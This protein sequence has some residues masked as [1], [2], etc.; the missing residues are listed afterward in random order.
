MAAR[1]TRFVVA[2]F[3]R[4]GYDDVVMATPL[5]AFVYNGTKE[6]NGYFRSGTYS[7]WDAS[8]GYPA[9]EWFGR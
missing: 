9:A 6:S 8:Y 4:R 2:D 5:G 1:N 7:I 3:I